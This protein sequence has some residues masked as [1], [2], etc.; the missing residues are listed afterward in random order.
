[1]TILGLA[2]NMDKIGLLAMQ[3][4]IAWSL[5]NARDPFDWLLRG[6]G[7]IATPA[8]FADAVGK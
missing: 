3:P 7:N 8:K 1:M 4:R 5:G 2:I 6:F